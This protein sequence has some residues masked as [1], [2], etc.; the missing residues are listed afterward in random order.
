[1][2]VVWVIGG[3]EMMERRI[4][5]RGGKMKR[6]EF[7]KTSVFSVCVILLGAKLKPAQKIKPTVISTISDFDCSNNKLLTIQTYFNTDD[8]ELVDWDYLD[9]RYKSHEFWLLNH[10]FN[11]P[12]QTIRSHYKP[13]KDLYHS[14]STTLITRKEDLCWA[15]RNIRGGKYKN[16]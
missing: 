13:K 11:I 2:R 6:R 10:D 9:G 3:S 5:K 16:G 14:T 8:L 12:N 7:C 1:M 4:F 15:F